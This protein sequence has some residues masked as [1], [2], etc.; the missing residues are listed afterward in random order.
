[1]SK[2]NNLYPEMREIAEKVLED[3]NRYCKKHFPE[4]TPTIT[5][6]F[7]SAEYQNRLYQKG[8]TKPGSIV[9]HMDG[10]KKKSNHQSGMA[11]DVAFI[12]NKKLTWDVAEELWQ[13]YGHVVRSYNLKWGGDWKT[14]LD[15]PHAE[16]NT[17]DKNAYTRA[18]NWL[19]KQGLK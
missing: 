11:F 7:R 2:L 3:L 10:Y 18:A 8:R 17:A 12:K 19:K 9:T 1:M 16:W 13:Y 15:R 4:F 6:G 14:F 5:E